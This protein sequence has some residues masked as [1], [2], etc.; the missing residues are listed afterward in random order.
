MMNYKVV[1]EQIFL[2]GVD[3][4][5]P[6]RLINKSVSI[7]GN[8]LG[9]GDHQFDLDSIENIYVIGAGKASALMGA[10]VERILGERITDGHIVVKYGHSCRTRRITVSEAGHPVPDSGS[11]AAAKSILGISDKAGINDLVICLLSGGGSSLMSDCPDSITPDQMAEFNRIIVNSGATIGEI[12]T[13]RK[14][15]SN[16]KGGQLARA[17]YPAALV[18]LILSDVINDPLDV[19][20]SGPTVPDPSTFLRA[21]EILEKYNLVDSVLP[22]IT[23]HLTDG[24]NRLIPETPKELDPIFERTYNILVGNNRLALGAAKEKAGELNIDARILDDS[25]EGEV[26]IVARE[27]VEAARKYQNDEITKPLCLL[28]GGEPTI[29]VTGRGEGGRNQHLALLVSTLLSEDKGITVLSAG[30]DG[31]DGPTLAAGAV[32]DCNTAANAISH[33]INPFDYLSDFDS[34]NFFR[35]AGGHIITGPTLT[36]VMDIIVIIVE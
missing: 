34:Y 33:G 6:D 12:N 20:A 31:S 16:V 22:A 7:E 28:M 21:M 1:A 32:V 24:M 9:I 10:E 27:V 11:F 18:S 4:V 3:R 25:L 30:T 5:L 8:R 2:A 29:K 26:S 23:N 15:L 35:I 17:V 13:L 19:I 36:N 14:H